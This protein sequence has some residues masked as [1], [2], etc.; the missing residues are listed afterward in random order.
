MPVRRT[1]WLACF[2][3]VWIAAI[4]C[5]IIFLQVIRHDHY[6][7]VAHA[8]QVKSVELFAP[9]GTILDRHEQTL[10][11]SVPVESVFVNPKR[12]PNAEVAAQVMAPIVKLK[13]EV[14]FDRLQYALGHPENE[15]FLWVKRKITPRESSDLRSLRLDWIEFQFQNQRHYPKDFVGSHVIGLLDHDGK[16][17]SGLEL[18]LDKK[19]RG[20]PGSAQVLKDGGG[21][22]IQSRTVKEPKAGMNLILTIDERIQFFVEAALKEAV[23]KARCKR[24][25]VVV[26]NPQSG[27]ILAMASYPPFDPKKPSSTVNRAVEEPFEP[28]S[29]LKVFTLATALETTRLRPDSKLP[30]GVVKLP[31]RVIHEAKHAFGELSFADVLILSSNAGAVQIGMLVGK[32]NLYKFFTLF[33]LGQ[34]TDSQLPYE[35]RGRLRRPDLWKGDTIGSV[36]M[37]H[38]MSVTTLQLAQGCSVIANGGLLVKPRLVLKWQNPDGSYVMEPPQ[39]PVRVI[40]PET[41]FTMRPIMEG[42]V[43]RG[44]GKAARLDEYSTA[45]KTGSAQIYDYDHKRYTHLYNASFMGFAPVTNPAVVV[46]VTMNE[47]SQYGGLVAAPVFKKIT[48]EVL[49]ILEVPKDAQKDLPATKEPADEDKNIADLEPELVEEPVQTA[50]E[51][52]GPRVPNFQGKTMRTVAAEASAMGLPLVMDGRGIARMQAPAAGAILPPGERVRVRFVK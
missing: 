25:S 48:T 36:P 3:A 5:R 22:A 10:A 27:E 39:R 41:A 6:A 37:G 21:R 43:F 1:A 49:R 15:G 11:M 20:E 2:G 32:E 28:G 7:K 35:S 31:G 52:G 26:M 38:E 45:G 40:K 34:K 17:S 46:V 47:S 19:L 9:R 29:V 18:G 42:V 33:G 13:H 44:T 4:F 51:S 14:L 30:C 50:A 24:G 12:L 23:E 16:G 8:Q